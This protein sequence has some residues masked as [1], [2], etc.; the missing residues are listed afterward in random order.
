MAAGTNVNVVEFGTGS[1][2]SGALLAHL[3]S[4]NGQVTSLD[5]DRYLT[6]WADL[7]HHERSAANIRAFTADGT[8]SFTERGPDDRTVG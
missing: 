5:I 4:T 3:V 8:T 2:C 6:V 7:I 1:G